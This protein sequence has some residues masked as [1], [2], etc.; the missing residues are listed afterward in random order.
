VY[1][2]HA[3]LQKGVEGLLLPPTEPEDSTAAAASTA[4]ASAAAAATAA[5]QQQQ[6]QAVEPMDTGATDAETL[7]AV[8]P[9]SEPNSCTTTEQLPEDL[10]ISEQQSAANVGCNDASISSN[11]PQNPSSKRP[12]SVSPVPA[13]TS[14]VS[15]ATA[16][17]ATAGLST[18]TSDSAA[19][20][21]PAEAAAVPA[22]A[23]SPQQQQ[24][25]Q[26]PLQLLCVMRHG[27]R[28]D[29]AL[30]D[31]AKL[32]S[33]KRGDLPQSDA[34]HSVTVAPVTAAADEPPALAAA[35]AVDNSND[36]INSSAD[37]AA[38]WTD[39]HDR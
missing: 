33:K 31:A 23:M 27:A 21:V 25:K 34:P 11:S 2:R 6:L 37:V 36:G 19:V 1:L 13:T 18:P 20:A 15:T 10:V 4:P 8:T 14:T 5:Q 3:V 24:H 9:V 29:V 16:A 7:V 39:R 32:A 35:A 26:Q 17:T 22:K 12:R 28:L 30:D 38:V